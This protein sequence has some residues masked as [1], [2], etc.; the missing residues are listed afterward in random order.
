MKNLFLAL[1]L[2]VLAACGGSGDG[3]I[4]DAGA[5]SF[6]GAVPQSF[7][8]LNL[9]GTTSINGV[10]LISASN[11]SNLV[12]CGAFPLLVPYNGTAAFLVKVGTGGTASQCFVTMPTAKTGWM[13]TATSRGQQANA[14]P[15]ADITSPTAVYITNY[16]ITSASTPTPFLAGEEIQVM[17]NGY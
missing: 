16:L 6:G 2:A 7:F 8:N 4:S 15:K 13:C 5:G 9:T 14:N 12:S 11:P 3:V 1:M 17:C 10:P